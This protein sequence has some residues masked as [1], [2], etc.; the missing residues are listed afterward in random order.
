MSAL[1]YAE[2]S[3]AVVGAIESLGPAPSE[4]RPAAANPR[5]QQAVS[6]RRVEA[7][8]GEVEAMFVEV[9]RGLKAPSGQTKAVMAAV[10]EGRPLGSDSTPAL[11]ALVRGL[12]RQ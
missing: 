5:L 10:L 12:G 1:P 7:R 8:V 4:E 3:R 6:R 11:E 2:R 9:L